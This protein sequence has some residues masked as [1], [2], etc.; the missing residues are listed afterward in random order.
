[1]AGM[2]REFFEFYPR[3]GSGPRYVSVSKLYAV[4]RGKLGCTDMGWRD[5]GSWYWITPNGVPFPVADPALDPDSK[6]VVSANGR[7]ELYFP[8][9]YV[10]DLLIRVKGIMRMEAPRALTT[11][12]GARA[13]AGH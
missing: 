4:L 8:Y 1:M 12:A 2:E 11:M 9:A 5:R 3:Q 10:R 13:N 7:R 6:A